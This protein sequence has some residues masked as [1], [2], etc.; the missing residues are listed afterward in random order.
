MAND[1]NAGIN[2]NAMSPSDVARVL[3]RVGGHPVTL[4]MLEADIAAGAPMN[5]DGTMSLLHY[6]A[7]LVKEMGRGD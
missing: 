1:P 4:V 6:A 5:T 7:W 2:P 3:S